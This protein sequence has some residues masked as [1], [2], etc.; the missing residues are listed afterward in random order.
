MEIRQKSEFPSPYYNTIQYLIGLRFACLISIK[1]VHHHQNHCKWTKG[2]K[3]VHWKKV[4]CTCGFTKKHIFLFLS[5]LLWVRHPP[6]TTSSHKASKLSC[7]N[8]LHL[9]TYIHKILRTSYSGLRGCWKPLREK[10]K[11]ETERGQ[12]G[13]NLTRLPY[14]SKKACGNYVYCILMTVGY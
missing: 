1:V 13:G 14:E 8:T 4:M 6:E 12:R 2:V 7:K 10:E 9:C 5:Y 11:W 3:I